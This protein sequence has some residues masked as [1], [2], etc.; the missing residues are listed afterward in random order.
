MS[1]LAERLAALPAEKRALLKRRLRQQP[2]ELATETV[3][4]LPRGAE[5]Y[6]ASFAQERLWFIEQW[7]QL[8]L[9]SEHLLL[10]IQGKLQGRLLHR[11][12]DL[13]AARHESLRT[14]F[15]HT[16]DGLR[17]RLQP[18]LKAE[19][20]RLDLS[21]LP[22]AHRANEM[23]RL[24][25]QEGRRPFRLDQAPLFRLQ[26]YL[27][28]PAV[29]VLGLTIHHIIFDAWSVG[30]FF[31][32]LF[33][34]YSSL[35]RGERPVLTPLPVQMI[36]FAAW[37]RE[38]VLQESF[39]QRLAYWRRELSLVPEPLDLPGDF[40]R[41][42]VRSGRGQRH[43]FTLS[44]GLTERLSFLG[45]RQDAT[46]FMTL[47][48]AFAALLHRLSAQ[49]RIA[50][51]IPITERARPEWEPVVGLFVNTVVVVADVAPGESFEGLL[52]QVRQRTLMAQTHRDVPFER[53]VEELGQ[54]RDLSRPPLFQVL[55][56]VQTLPDPPL[57]EGLSGQL[58]E[59]PRETAKFDLYLV[60]QRTEG[61]L[62]A[63][64]EYNCDLFT[65]TTIR[66]WARAYRTL[67]EHLSHHPETAVA[68]LPLLSPSARHQVRVE[69]NDVEAPLAGDGMTLAQLAARGAAISADSVAVVSGDRSLTHRALW[70]RVRTLARALQERGIGAEDRVAV[71]LQR[72][73][74]LVVALLAVLEAGAAY[75]PLD[76]DHPPER[77]RFVLE[78]SQADLLLTGATVEGHLP[79][80][81]VPKMLLGDEGSF[82]AEAGTKETSPL[83]LPPCPPCRESL[84]YV[85]YTSGSTGRP[86]GVAVSHGAAVNF[87]LSMLRRPGLGPRDVL[88]AVTTVAFDISLLELFGPL[89][90]GGRVVLAD[91][92]STRD[93]RRLA[94]LLE[95]S[96]ATVMQATPAGWQMVL[97]SGWTPP[98]G[99]RILCGGQELPVPLARRLGGAAQ[100]WNLYGPTET[101]VWSSLE[102]VSPPSL[103]VTSSVSLGR[104]L[105]NTHLVATDAS[106]RPCLPGTS[107]ELTIGGRGLARGYL[108]RPAL[109]AAVF[110]PDP[111]GAAP[112][113][114]RYLTGDRARRLP[115]GRLE[116]LG[117]RDRQVKIH[118]FRIEPA[119]IE[120]ALLEHPEVR[121]AT[122]VTAQDPTGEEARLV[123]FITGTGSVTGT[124]TQEELSKWL[125]FKVPT[126]LIPAE[127]RILEALPLTPNNK[128]DHSALQRLAGKRLQA[129]LEDATESSLRQ[130][131]WTETESAVRALF[132]EML[133][134]PPQQVL[135][136]SSFFTLG[137]HSLLTTRLLSAVRDSLEADVSLIDFFRQPTVIGLAEA[138]ERQRGESLSARRDAQRDT[139]L[140]S[141]LEERLETLPACL[142]PMQ[143]GSP[144]EPTSSA[145]TPG[146]PIFWVPPAAGS[147]LCYLELVR[148]LDP[149][150]SSWGLQAPG[151]RPGESPLSRVPELAAHFIEGMRAVSPQGPYRI[152]GWSFGAVVAWEMARQLAESGTQVEL[153]ALLDGGMDQWHL[154]RMKNPWKAV[155]SAGAV[156][157]IAM[158]TGLPRSYEE[159]RT[160]VSWLGISLPPSAA[161]AEA[162]GI[163]AKWALLRG[164]RPEVARSLRVLK[165]TFL[166]GARYRLPPYSGAASL[167][168]TGKFQERRDDYLSRLQRLVHGSLEVS[169]IPGNHMTLIMDP[170]NVRVLAQRLAASLAP[171]SHRPSAAAP[172]LFGSSVPRDE[173]GAKEGLASLHPEHGPKSRAQNCSTQT[174]TGVKT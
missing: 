6:P 61:G 37:Q 94:A 157:R 132:A 35:Q 63:E 87:L 71:A 57:P 141:R 49:Q 69:W 67:L 78:E 107:G 139:R 33:A 3:A 140:S 13:L 19:L 18:A 20:P 123:A 64:L 126:Y 86:K 122:V 58:L 81:A 28:E 110:V 109:T 166:A 127:I 150:L 149:L 104:P 91:R 138:V 102:K 2:T 151:L 22:A 97:D 14:S 50:L 30:V 147:P 84:A 99:F 88:V 12:V 47:L 38:Q 73:P 53:L 156:L 83:Q 7:E 130:R 95:T 167:F 114:R 39:Q 160:L 41:P 85:L 173:F 98:D 153:L 119:E 112:G 162:G 45:R 66:R 1:Q 103:E 40:P 169:S 158:E 111:F 10:R 90:A 21:S 4:R 165:A 137:G 118:G 154:S 11:A 146:S 115:D 100:L 65:N 74:E 143:L 129:Q 54:R 108:S 92:E 106:L 105:D 43:H 68:D 55:F 152:A 120:A 17:Q 171:P 133:G 77:L 16:E 70:Q 42:P 5:S 72:G 134:I 121:E 96:G 135:A 23:D 27:L 60:L 59:V 163:P 9:Y 101:T 34:I 76:P 25:G 164:L 116:F 148:N 44:P 170:H 79:P 142:V 93:G 62:R 159:L 56:D 131:T 89:A 174:S 113:S 117:R 145:P 15:T 144:T 52:S 155:T 31:R 32:E 48:T 80:S 124:G 75:I 8:P 36:E 168:R 51:G 128:V 82:A 46:L 26:L 172:H 161:Y 29:Q 24:A 136:D 125:S